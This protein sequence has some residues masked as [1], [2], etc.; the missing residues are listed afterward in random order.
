MKPKLVLLLI[1]ALLLA[2]IVIQNTETM[3]VTL[4]AWEFAISRV[5]LILGTGALGFLLGF[6]TAKLT[7]GR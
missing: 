4:L 3:T 5:V 1:V 6:V 2:I 7:G